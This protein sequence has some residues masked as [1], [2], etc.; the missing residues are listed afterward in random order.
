MW[1]GVGGVY[2]GVGVLACDSVL[3]MVLRDVGRVAM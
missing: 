3:S 1:V 2:V